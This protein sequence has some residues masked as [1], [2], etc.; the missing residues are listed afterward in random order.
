MSTQAR[1]DSQ[2]AIVD[3]LKPGTSDHRTAT[4][5]LLLLQDSLFVLTQAQMLLRAA[6]EQSA[7]NRDGL[8]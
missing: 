3:K 2:A 5:V 6:R 4:S 1:I 7:A 8:T